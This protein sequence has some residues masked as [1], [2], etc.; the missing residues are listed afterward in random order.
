MRTLVLIGLAGLASAA[1]ALNAEA[2]GGRFHFGGLRIRGPVPAAAIHSIPRES[3][4]APGLAIRPDLSVGARPTYVVLPSPQLRPEP[5]EARSAGEAGAP[6]V[7]PVAETPAPAAAKAAAQA[8]PWCPSR[9]I[10]GT[11]AG[12]CLIN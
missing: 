11:G 8:A 4:P 12:F 2:R 1:G 5:V 9:R 6:A 10:V 3:A 7:R